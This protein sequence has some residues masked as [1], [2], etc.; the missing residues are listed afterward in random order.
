MNALRGLRGLAGYAR[1][2]ARRL[3][4]AAVP[5]LAATPSERFFRDGHNALI[6]KRLGLGQQS[7]VLDFGGYLGDW[8]AEIVER[9]GCTV[10]VFEPVPDFA[11]ALRRR[12]DSDNRVVVHPVA[13][14]EAPGSRSINLAG[15]ASGAGVVGEPVAIEVVGAQYLVDHGIAHPDLVAMNIEGGEYEL[16]LAL[17][18]QGILADCERVF[19]QFH[20][21]DA[22]SPARREACH[23]VLVAS[24]RCDWDYPFVWE[25][26]TRERRR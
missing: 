14:G 22:S 4:L 21:V 5:G 1:R 7:I 18:H 25:S 6:T 10:H 17:A 20:V 19:I 8:A 26:W 12:F 24:H 9:Y 11:A 23:A 2:G 13:V 15:D 3:R 16:L